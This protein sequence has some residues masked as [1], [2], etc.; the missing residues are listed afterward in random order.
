MAAIAAI[1]LDTLKK[2]TLSVPS[3]TGDSVPCDGQT[4]ILIVATGATTVTLTSQ[5]DSQGRTE[6]LT[7]ALVAGTYIIGPLYK[8][9]GW[10]TPSGKVLISFGTPANATFA[11]FKRKEF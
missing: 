3:A 2:I 9:A 4:G 8:S 1:V 7:Q 11:A 10:A 6:D 5:A